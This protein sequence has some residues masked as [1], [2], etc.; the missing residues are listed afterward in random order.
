[1]DGR[2]GH[3]EAGRGSF[4]GVLGHADTID[5]AGS[6]PGASWDVIPNPFCYGRMRTQ[7]PQDQ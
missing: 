5:A 3:A 4:G 1:V 6:R 7:F 2:V